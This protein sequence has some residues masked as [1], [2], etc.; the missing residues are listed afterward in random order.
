M[1]TNKVS[2]IVC[3]NDEAALYECTL[4]IKQLAIPEGFS[5]D[6]IPIRNAASM[7]QG[8]DQGMNASDAKYKVYL[9]QDVLILNKNFIADILT[10]FQK[11]N[12]IGLIG[13]VGTK[14]L[15]SNGCMWS[16]AMRTGAVRSHCISTVDD[17]FNIPVSPTRMYSPVEAIDG[18]LMATSQDIP[19]RSDLFTGWDFYDISQSKEFSRA[20]YLIAVPYQSS[21]WVLHDTGF[22]NLK[23]YHQYRKVFL[24]EYCPENRKEIDAC[25]NYMTSTDSTQALKTQASVILLELLK[26]HN[27]DQ[28]LRFAQDNLAQNQEN[29][30]FCILTI[31]L[32]IYQ[33]EKQAGLFEIFVPLETKDLSID[34][35][36]P[37]HY[38]QICRHLWRLEYQLPQKEQETAMHYFDTWHVS[39][40]AQEYMRNLCM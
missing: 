25:R 8:Y 6:I 10:I 31:F 2:F 36:L 33:L 16:N 23:N 12:K 29:E 1:D 35:W 34:T 4:Y 15:H 9:H 5:V 40:I 39:K 28:A 30:L 3:T 26:N 22:M 18:L 24:E 17:Y 20:G 11:N 19:W 21:P 37:A 13:M 14:Q 38:A 32:Q 7:A 27:Y